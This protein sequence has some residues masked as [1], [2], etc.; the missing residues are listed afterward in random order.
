M[1]DLKERSTLTPAR[2]ATVRPG[3]TRRTR[4]AVLGAAMALGVAAGWLGFRAVDQ[5]TPQEIASLRAEELVT[6]HERLWRATPE[7]I[8]RARAEQMVEQHRRLWEARQ[9]GSGG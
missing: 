3:P 1:T 9:E 5:P 8:Q 7:E 2:P 4:L 6:V